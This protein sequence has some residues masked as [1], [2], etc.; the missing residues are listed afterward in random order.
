MAVIKEINDKII[1]DSQCQVIVNAVNCMGVMG[2]GIALEYKYRY[3]KMFDEYLKLCESNIIKPG[4]LHI[5]DKV[6]PWILNFP[7]KYN[8]KYP[9]KIEYI[10]KG[11]VE[12]AKIYKDKQIKSIAFPQLGCSAGGLEWPIV[13]ELLY[14]YLKPL[15][16]LEVE[17]YHYSPFVK[18][19]YYSNFKEQVKNFNN[20]DF[21]KIYNIKNSQTE[22]LLN[23][24]NSD[25][26]TMSSLFR[27]KGLGEKAIKNIFDSLKNKGNSGTNTDEYE[28][29]TLF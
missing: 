8:W 26:T 24:L 20:D 1:F 17:I 14:R 13:K 29:L 6:S 27:V 22:A 9:S 2:R 28:Q 4:Y 15:S 10:Q 23:V 3:P 21:K 11:F 18:D 19:S 12:F 5:W 7:T 25:K 16:E